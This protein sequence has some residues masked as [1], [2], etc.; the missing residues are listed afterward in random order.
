MVT[1][2][3]MVS[4]VTTG[5]ITTKNCGGTIVATSTVSD[6]NDQPSF[7]VTPENCDGGES[8]TG[9]SLKMCQQEGL[10]NGKGFVGIIFILLSLVV[11][12]AGLALVV[13]SGALCVTILCCLVAVGITLALLGMG[14]IL[15][16]YGSL[17]KAEAAMVTY[18]AEEDLLDAFRAGLCY[19]PQGD[20]PVLHSWVW[21]TISEAW[22]TAS[23][24]M[25]TT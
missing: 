20:P 13:L 24:S 11:L 2:R 12:G 3:A 22:P 9:S 7:W 8:T 15:S 1:T 6:W 5:S 14:L 16:Q 21:S 23:G 18:P 25:L 4:P 10:L 17:K 19:G